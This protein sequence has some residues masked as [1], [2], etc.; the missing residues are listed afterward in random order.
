MVRPLFEHTSFCL[1]ESC[2]LVVVG[3]GGGYLCIGGI[4]V[5]GLRCSCFVVLIFIEIS[6]TFSTEDQ[7][8]LRDQWG[9]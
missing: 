4:T 7:N 8:F 5:V 3:G 2:G 1:S 9:K 6:Y